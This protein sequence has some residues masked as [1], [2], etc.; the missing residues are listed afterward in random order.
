MYTHRL[1]PPFVRGNEAQNDRILQPR[2]GYYRKWIDEEKNALMKGKKQNSRWKK[3]ESCNFRC[4]WWKFIIEERL[5]VN[6]ITIIIW[7][8]SSIWNIW[9]IILVTPKNTVLFIS[10]LKMA[11]P[12]LATWEHML[13]YV[14]VLWN[15][16]V[17]VHPSQTVKYIPQQKSGPSSLNWWVATFPRD[18]W[19]FDILEYKFQVT[20]SCA[21]L[22]S[23]S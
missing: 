4:K 11:S 2:W 7:N 22:P 1:T 10:A 5:Y 6:R 3:W 15:V 16:K 9:T 8:I 12:F 19:F 21:I 18:S 23:F 14:C 17:K 20:C 13:T